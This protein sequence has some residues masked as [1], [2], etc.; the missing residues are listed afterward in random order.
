MRKIL[1]RGKRTGE[2]RNGKWACGNLQWFCGYEKMFQG[3]EVDSVSI[4]DT[5]NDFGFVEKSY[6]DPETVGQWTGL[7]DKND[8]CIFEGDIV[9]FECPVKVD[10]DLY[11]A[12]GVFSF[13]GYVVFEDC[14]FSLKKSNKNG[15]NDYVKL[16]DCR[17]KVEFHG[18]TME[19]VGNIHDNP[20]LV[21]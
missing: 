2:F 10:S 5:A 18:G 1:F 12:N 14:M 19:I 13:T 6:V 11:I 3:K 7:Y 20:E 4:V 9:K 17:A 8:N 16:S 21:N 15:G